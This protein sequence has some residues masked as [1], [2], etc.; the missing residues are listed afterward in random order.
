MKE[1][2]ITFETAKL[3]K[4]RGFNNLE[5]FTYFYTKP[6]SKM[7]GIDEEGRSY[8]I[9]N[10]SKKLYKRGEHAALR[11][12]NIIEAPTQSLL[13]K[14]LREKYKIDLTVMI[15]FADS[16]SVIIHQNRDVI[17]EYTGDNVIT[18]LLRKRNRTVENYST[19]EII[20]D[21]TPENIKR[22]VYEEALEKGLQETLKLI[23]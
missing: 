15:R 13:Q 19:K 3:A 1:Q 10:T 21:P 9:K 23:K 22:G 8:P 4:E 6:N 20:V 12:E 14:W 5:S 11:V 2:L 7:F 16:Y 18:R 17:K